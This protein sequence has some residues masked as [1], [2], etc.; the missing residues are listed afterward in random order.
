M[1][2][3][4]GPDC[5]GDVYFE[6]LNVPAQVY[7]TE[8]EKER[9]VL[10]VSILSQGKSCLLP[11]TWRLSKGI[12]RSFRYCGALPWTTFCIRTHL[13]HNS[14]LSNGSNL[15]ARHFCILSISGVGII[16]L[17]LLHV[18]GEKTAASSIH[19]HIVC[20]P[21]VICEHKTFVCSP[22]LELAIILLLHVC[23]ENKAASSVVWYTHP[24]HLK[25]SLHA[26]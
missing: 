2:T 21:E 26:T 6:A 1:F 25:R 14:C 18:C 17:F 19:W 3:A 22:Y 12:M 10:K 8:P 9:L 7:A 20:L 16:Y 23:G 5:C 24:I 4:D 15:R 13:L 11:W